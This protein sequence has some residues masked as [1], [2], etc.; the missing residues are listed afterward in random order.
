M[1]P[2]PYA[3]ADAV[4]FITPRVTQ[5]PAEINF[6]IALDDSLIGGIGVRMK[7]TSHLQAGPGPNLGYWLGQ[8]YWGRGY[9]TE[10]AR[11]IVVH[12]FASGV[13]E[14]IYSGAFA[15]NA[16]SLRVQEKLGFVRTGETTLYAKPRGAEFP[17]VNTVLTRDAFE[18][19]RR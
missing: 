18:A 15:D 10:A 7:D 4:D 11:G 6:A 16:A 2:W 13:S 3:L 9:M 17:H 5:K 8:P 19:C 12:A 1:P 14:T